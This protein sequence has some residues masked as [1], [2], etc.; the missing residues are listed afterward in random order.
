MNEL[1][2]MTENEYK[3][4]ALL[5]KCENRKKRMDEQSEMR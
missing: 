3:M 5:T 4:E 2:K 1:S